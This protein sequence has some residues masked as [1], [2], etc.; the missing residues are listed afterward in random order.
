MADEVSRMRIPVAT[1][2]AAQRQAQEKGLCQRKEQH[3]EGEFAG[4]MLAA[5]LY[6]GSICQCRYREDRRAQTRGDGESV[7]LHRT[8]GSGDICRVSH[9]G[10]QMESRTVMQLAIGK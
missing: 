3:T 9:K 6:D 4:G 7:T 10:W 2:R 8:F 5:Y 1:L